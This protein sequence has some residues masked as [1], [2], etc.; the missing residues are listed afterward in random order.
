MLGDGRRVLMLLV[1]CL[2]FFSACKGVVLANDFEYRTKAENVAGMGEDWKATL[3][4]ES[5]HV[6]KR[7]QV[8]HTLSVD[9]NNRGLRH[10][11]LSFRRLQL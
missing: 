8:H 5:R 4:F 2:L 3:S 1:W 7:E 6:D 11:F 10:R 9:F